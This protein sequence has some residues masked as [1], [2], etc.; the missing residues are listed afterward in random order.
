MTGMTEQTLLLIGGLA[1]FLAALIGFVVGRSPIGGKTKRV[2]ALEAEVSRQQ[3]EIAGYR[4]DVESHFDKTA[5]LVAS[6]AGSYKDLFEHLSSGY[7]HLSSGSARQL[8]RDRVVGLL[9]GNVSAAAAADV[10]PS[11]KVSAALIAAG[12]Q[13]LEPSST[14]PAADSEPAAAAGDTAPTEAAATDVAAKADGE[15]EAAATAA[16]APAQ[17]AEASRGKASKPDGEEKSASDGQ[18]EAAETTA[19]AAGEAAQNG[20]A[21]DAGK[22]DRPTKTS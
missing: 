10:T 21:K 9:V 6:M 1:V 4:R 5:T 2:A 7:E 22:G 20:A 12:A 16:G 11:D 19:A 18:A 3:D 14:G 15:A 13:P 17:E 8:F